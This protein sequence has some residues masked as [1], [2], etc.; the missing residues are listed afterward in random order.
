MLTLTV[1][2]IRERWA[3][4][5]GALLSVAVGVALLASAMTVAAS[6]RPPDTGGLSPRAA[7]EVRDA[8]DSVA[9]VMIIS[10]MLAGLLTVFIVATTFA[11]TVAERRRDIALLRLLGAGRRQVRLVLLGETIALGIV[12]SV[13]GVLLTRP[14]VSVQ[15][16]LLRRADFVPDGF[17]VTHPSWPLWAAAGTGIGVAVLGVLAASRR[18]SRV[19]PMEAI[20]DSTGR[21]RVMTPGRWIVGIVMLLATAAEIIAAAFVGLVVALALGLGGAIT[22]A[23]AL[24]QLAP[25][26]LPVTTRVLGLP[27]RTTTLGTLADANG[28]EG[29][30]RSASTA[31]PVIVLVALVISITS[32]LAATSSAVTIEE[33]DHTN[34]DLVVSTTGSHVSSLAH[35]PGV[36][37]HHR[38]SPRTWSS[39][40]PARAATT[41]MTSASTTAMPSSTPPDMP[42]STR[43]TRSPAAS[44]TS[45]AAPS[46]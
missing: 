41:T 20:R 30:Q 12:G 26:V 14:A 17:T 43:S 10:A 34:A 19:P 22:G 33:L 18:A 6:A 40:Y 29:I 27:L 21:A 23:I 46:P 28:R 2:G 36:A 7:V 3:L 25:A 45:R 24:S 1:A 35:L 38:R 16:W 11:F 15:M 44:G 9:T 5:V 32:A 42:P 8:F 4:L 13:V 37:R 31:A 39:T